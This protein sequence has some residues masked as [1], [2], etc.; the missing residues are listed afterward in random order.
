MKSSR[1]SKQTKPGNF[2][3]MNFANVVAG[4]EAQINPTTGF[5]TW[6]RLVSNSI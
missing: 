4:N 1:H 6:K 3:L 2:F 5:I